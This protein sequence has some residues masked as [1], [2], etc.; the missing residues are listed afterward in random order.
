MS[1]LMNNFV[2]TQA[3]MNLLIEIITQAPYSIATR[4]IAVL[5]QAQQQQPQPGPKQKT[6][7]EA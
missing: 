5:Q 4:A 2:I 1:K 3:Q 6:K 7:S